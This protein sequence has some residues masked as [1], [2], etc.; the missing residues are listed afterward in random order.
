MDMEAKKKKK[1]GLI[2]FY[3]NNFGSILQCYATKT[4]LESMGYAC[5]VLD[6]KNNDI[7]SNKSI[8]SQCVFK[9][10]FII[11]NSLHDPSFF[12]R[13]VKTHKEP[14]PL[15]SGSLYLME[16]FVNEEIC[17]ISYTEKDIV[18][19]ASDYWAFIVGSDQVWN[20]TRKMPDYYFLKFAPDNKKIAFA[21]SFGR[22]NPE[23]KFLN[24]IKN[25]IKGFNKISVREESGVDII[26]YCSDIDVCRISDPTVMLTAE[27]WRK[28]SCN[29]HIS[30][31][32]YVLVHFLDSPSKMAIEYIEKKS[33]GRN[34]ICIAYRYEIYAEKGWNYVDCGPREYVAYINYADEI[35]TDSFH[36]TLFSINLNKQLYTFERQYRHG[37]SQKDRIC[38]LLSRYMLGD[39]FICSVDSIVSSQVE[40]CANVICTERKITKDYLCSALDSVTED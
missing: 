2:T 15:Q 3:N 12:Q 4:V 17:P 39:R 11:K 30:Y 13:W 10:C 5:D 35:Y 32:N 27:E 33:K 16:E 28:F 40:T 34:I 25:N 22:K 36:T 21:V 38:D 24:T 7:K 1:I 14:D 6:I 26:R 31:N 37:Y 20:V 23:K 19:L 9:L 8:I 18:N 29:V